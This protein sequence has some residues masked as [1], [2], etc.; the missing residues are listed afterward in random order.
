MIG[1]WH[2]ASTKNLYKE[3]GGGGLDC[4]QLKIVR[5]LL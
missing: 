4:R 1:G 5:E 2:K 3:L